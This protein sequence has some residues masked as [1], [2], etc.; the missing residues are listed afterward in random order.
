[1]PCPRSVEERRFSS[2]ISASSHPFPKL[3]SKPSLALSFFSL[4]FSKTPRKTSKIP[5]IF[6]PCKPLGPCAMTTKLLDNQICTFKILLS[7]RFQR[8]IAFWTILLSA[9]KGPPPSKSENFIF[10]VVSPSL[11][12]EKPCKKTENT[13]KDQGNSQEEKHQ[14]NKNSKEKKD[15]VVTRPKV[16]SRRPTPKNTHPPK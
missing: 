15:K 11:N 6:S 7:W 16:K 3:R 4:V 8:K 10:I 14:G 1:M 9:T 2:L 13:Q 5:R 12:L